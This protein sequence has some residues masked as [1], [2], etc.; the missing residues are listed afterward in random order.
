MYKISALFIIGI[1]AGALAADILVIREDT[2]LFTDSTLYEKA[3]VLTLTDEPQII[4]I[5]SETENGYGVE[6]VDSLF[7]D[8]ITGYVNARSLENKKEITFYSMAVV[9]GSLVYSQDFSVKY[10]LYRDGRVVLDKLVYVALCE[11]GTID[12]VYCKYAFLEKIDAIEK[13]AK[14]LMAQID[15][16]KRAKTKKKLITDLAAVQS[17]SFPIQTIKV[18]FSSPRM[19]KNPV[20]SYLMIDQEK[21]FEVA[22]KDKFNACKYFVRGRK[23]TY[24]IRKGSALRVYKDEAEYKAHVALIKGREDYV[25]TNKVTGL[26]AKAI[27]TG[28]IVLDMTGPDVVASLGTPIDKTPE[29]ERF[30]VLQQTWVYKDFRLIFF[31][32]K[33]VKWE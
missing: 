32:G 24:W 26:K 3:A 21:F 4:T 6:F 1:L 18:Q 30:G 25:R 27:L 2:P 9:E 13:K 12:T 16:T 29:A 33:L 7:L 19:V 28:K 8:S 17:Q 22:S 10:D 11:K 23:A 5:Q 31:D 20:L 15:K 14:D